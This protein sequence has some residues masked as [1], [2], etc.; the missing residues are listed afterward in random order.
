M[1]RELI[2]TVA[3]TILRTIAQHASHVLNAIPPTNALTST[4]TL[5]VLLRC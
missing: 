4:C 2:D 1:S 3:T 5:V